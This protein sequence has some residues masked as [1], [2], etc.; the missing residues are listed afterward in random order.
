MEIGV[1][2]FGEIDPDASGRTITPEQRM[3]NLIE[4][5]ETAD[6]VGLDVFAIGEHHRPDFVVSAPS[7]V[8]GAA[9]VR[10]E[11]I[12]LSS[13]V[14]VLSS[15]DPIRVMQDFATIDLLSG[16][17]AEIMAGRG[18]FTESFPLFGYDLADYDELFA[19]KLDLLINARDNE[20]V[21]WQ[22]RLRPSIDGRGVYP[23]PVQEKLPIWLAAG[24][25]PGSAVRA[26]E[27]GLPLGLAIIG[28]EPAGFAP[29][30]DLYRRAATAAGN[31]G[32][33]LGINS[34]G[35]IADTAEEAAEEAFMPLKTVMDRI[36]S[37]RGWPPM[38]RAQYDASRSLEGANFIGDPAQI[39]EK[40]L[41]QHQ[42]F[43]H[44]RFMIQFIVGSMPHEKVLRSIELL[45][46]EVA[47]AVRE[48][49]ARRG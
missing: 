3:A 1:F 10:T 35:F 11:N 37:E 39:I 28:G 41:H 45:G 34:H 40:I 24:G 17:R 21:E 38:S 36:G 20:I 44:D 23:R 13:A 33:P 9:A 15:E 31:P 5:V 29:F 7:V 4:E 42:I 46:T 19:E 27:L 26:G 48:E 8:L 16:G 25:N 22:G 32:L 30:A 49:I 47:P 14:T 12:R 43:K 6:R 18:S 2:T